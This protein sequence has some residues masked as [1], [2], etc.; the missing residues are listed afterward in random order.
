MKPAALV[1]IGLLAFLVTTLFLRLP[2]AAHDAV[3]PITAEANGICGGNGCEAAGHCWGAGTVGGNGDNGCKYVCNGS[4]WG[5]ENCN[6]SQAEK[7][8]YAALKNQYEQQVAAANAANGSGGSTQSQAAAAQATT[9]AAGSASGCTGRPFYSAPSNAATLVCFPNGVTATG[10][11]VC[12]RDTK[13]NVKV[14]TNPLTGKV[15]GGYL[16][17]AEGEGQK[18]ANGLPRTTSPSTGGC[19]AVAICGCSTG[20]VSLCLNSTAHVGSSVADYCAKTVCAPI[21]GTNKVCTPGQVS[22]CNG[23]TGKICNPDGKGW[24]NVCAHACGCKHTVAYC[25]ESKAGGTAATG[26]QCKG[27]TYDT[28]SE[29]EAQN[30]GQGS[31]TRGVAQV[32]QSANIAAKSCADA[33]DSKICKDACFTSVV[34]Q[35][36]CI[37]KG[38][39]TAQQCRNRYIGGLTVEATQVATNVVQATVAGTCPAKGSFSSFIGCGTGAQS[40]YNCYRSCVNGVE[41]KTCLNEP[42]LSCGAH[43]TNKIAQSV[44]TLETRLGATTPTTVTSPPP[45]NAPTPEPTPTPVAVCG[46]PCGSAA[47]G[48][49]CTGQ[50]Q[51]CVSGTCRSTL[52]AV[53]EQDNQCVCKPPSPPPMACIDIFASKTD[54]KLNDQV[55]FTCAEVPNAVRYEF[56]YAYVKAKTGIAGAIMSPL[57]PATATSRTSAPVTIDKVGRYVAQCRPCAA[58]DLCTEWEPLDGQIGGPKLEP[59][60]TA[61]TNNSI[62]AGEQ[63]GG[64]NTN[65]T[66]TTNTCTQAMTEDFSSADATHYEGLFGTTL[67]NGT[68]TFGNG[69]AKIAL[70]KTEKAGTSTFVFLKKALTGNVQIDVDVP[71]FS[72]GAATPVQGNSVLMVALPESAGRRQVLVRRQGTGT[73]ATIDFVLRTE[74]D[75]VKGTANVD[76]TAPISFRIVREGTKARGYYKQGTGDYV[77]LGEYEFGTGELTPQF[78]ANQFAETTESGVTATFDNFKVACVGA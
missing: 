22:E 43:E 54:I 23:Q 47:N 16:L 24:S 60:T 18:L 34:N 75:E 45:T 71:T 73:A 66:N 70:N 32:S 50:N 15:E 44:A 25:S 35:L 53:S 39:E 7:D 56:R 9:C 64:T 49:I 78:F 28:V 62:A 26:T 14:T 29:C 12:G 30:G 20:Q 1:R 33:C 77:L 19:P 65:T 51:A 38:L 69:S 74:T 59:A 68:V 67:N 8:Q 5:Q 41:S 40:K 21:D 58:N 52:C 17:S 27:L 3:V 6:T 76:L 31:C 57:S 63:T 46:Q 11:P 61:A 42:G 48:A 37:E 72:P 36:D 10:L 2:T 4:D 55:T 13:A